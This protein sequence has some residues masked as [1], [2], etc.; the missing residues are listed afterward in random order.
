MF[1]I[2]GSAG[3]GITSGLNQP[4]Q[5]YQDAGRVKNQFEYNR[6]VENAEKLN[7]LMPGT[8]ILLQ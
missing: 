3:T 1:R 8:I 2:G 5:Q 7:A 6:L 4:R